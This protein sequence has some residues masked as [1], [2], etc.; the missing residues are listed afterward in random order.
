MVRQG[1]VVVQGPNALPRPGL[2]IVIV[3]LRGALGW[4]ST[5]ISLALIFLDHIG[6]PI[7]RTE[8]AIYVRVCV[9]HPGQNFLLYRNPG[10]YIRCKRHSCAQ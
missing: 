7:C 4:E 3:P 8:Q 6:F 2:L 5:R 10:K 1:G 9:L